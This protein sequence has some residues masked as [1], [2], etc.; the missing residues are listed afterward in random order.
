MKVQIDVKDTDDKTVHSVTFTITRM[1]YE[2]FK[3]YINTL[4]A[5]FR[6]ES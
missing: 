2:M 5:K 1:Q 6:K 3:H 4:V